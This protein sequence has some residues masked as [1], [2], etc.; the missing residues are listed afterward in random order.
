MDKTVLIIK[1]FL[2]KS[3][4][5]VI[6]NRKLYS[7]CKKKN[8][9]SMYSKN[10]LMFFAPHHH[11]HT[12]SCN[13]QLTILGNASKSKHGF[14]T[15]HNVIWF[16]MTKQYKLKY[17]FFIRNFLSTSFLLV[18][19][20]TPKRIF[21]LCNIFIFNPLRPEVPKIHPGVPECACNWLAL[22]F[23]TQH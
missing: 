10:W 2:T 8:F 15:S 17:Y 14:H 11:T 1:K 16:W 5:L 18:K 3:D 12:S 13:F 4:E 20:Y 7:L 22:Y 19:I 23:S 6:L 21:K 9:I